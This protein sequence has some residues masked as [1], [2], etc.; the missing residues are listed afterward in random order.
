MYSLQKSETL[1]PRGLNWVEKKK[2]SYFM[3]F[4]EYSYFKCSE[5]N[6]TY[7]FY[8]SFCWPL[9]HVYCMKWF[10][11]IIDH[12]IF[13]PKHSHSL[14][15]TCIICRKCSMALKSKLSHAGWFAE[16]VSGVIFFFCL[17]HVYYG[18]V[19]FW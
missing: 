1:W 9:V 17:V 2:K 4:K 16:K 15:C 19:H 8:F 7:L 3:I 13:P 12:V 11:F 14:H 10:H 5:K 18:I 6:I